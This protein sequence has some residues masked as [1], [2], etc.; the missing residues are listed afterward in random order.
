[1]VILAGLEAFLEPLGAI[2]GPLG[3]VLVRSWSLWGRAWGSQGGLLIGKVALAQ[4]GEGFSG[5]R[6]RGAQ[7]RVGRRERAGGAF[8]DPPPSPKL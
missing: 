1:M 7:V 3:A 2:L 4:A 8:R 5:G 6:R